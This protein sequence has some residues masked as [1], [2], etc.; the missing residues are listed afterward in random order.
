MTEEVSLDL[1]LQNADQLFDENHY[2][3]VIDVLSKYSV[4]VNMWL[5][6]VVKLWVEKD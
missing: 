6:L 1:T 2:Q 3:E 5:N 4:S